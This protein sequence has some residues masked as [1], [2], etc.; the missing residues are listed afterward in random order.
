[1]T[2]Y[3]DWNPGSGTG[4][5]LYEKPWMGTAFTQ[6]KMFIFGF[7][8]GLGSSLV[9]THSGNHSHVGIYRGTKAPDEY[10]R[11]IFN[12]TFRHREYADLT[13]LQRLYRSGNTFD[14][15]VGIRTTDEFTATS[16][17]TYTLSRP[18][19]AGVVTGITTSTHPH[20][21]LLNGSS[22]PSAA[23][24]ATQ[25]V[26]ANNTG[27]ITVTYTPLFS[28]KMTSFNTSFPGEGI[29]DTTFV[30]E[31]SIEGDFG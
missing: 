20:E 17:Q 5:W 21:I 12:V 2:D 27:T 26:T 24:I 29:M 18:I 23:S 22:N 28:V 14:F 11:Y 9:Q 6:R 25:T 8:A 7:D 4:G 13:L 31:E 3:R 15:S 19:A 30:L 1:M 16:G 10:S